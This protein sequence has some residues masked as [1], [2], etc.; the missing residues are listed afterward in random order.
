MASTLPPTYDRSSTHP[1]SPAVDHDETA[2][3]NF[4]TNL[5]VHLNQQVFPGNR[6]AFEK[7]VAPA[8]QKTQGK[9]LE[10]RQQV[11]DA[12]RKDPHY[13]SWAALRRNTMEQ[14]QQAGRHVVLRQLDNLVNNAKAHNTGKDTLLLNKDTTVPR[15]LA[16]V[17]NHC[18]PGSYH[19]GVVDDDVLAGVNYEA[20]I[21]VTTAGSMSS[22]GD[23]GGRAVV[24]FVKQNAP[25]FKPRR[26]L[27]LGAGIGVNTLPI[28]AAYP[29][30]EVIAVDVG[31]PMLRWGHARAQALEYKNVRFIQADGDALDIEPNSI[32][33]VQ[34]TMFWHET[35]TSAFQS[36]MKKIY[37]MMTP[38]GLCLNVEQPNFTPDTSLYDQFTRDWDAWYNNE[39]FWSK[40]HVMDV[41]DVMAKAGFS[42]EHMFEGGT[43][44]DIEQGQFQ[45]W[46][47]TMS[48]HSAELHKG[49]RA[50]GNGDPADVSKDCGDGKDSKYKGERWYLFGG[51]K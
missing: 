11:R 31:A 13:Q 16:A 39:P 4:L 33:W 17:D 36:M 46:S 30:A 20:G 15:Y 2:R 3:F 47:S 42:K 23:G 44:A 29:E 40:L 28:A 12:M 6:L 9:A 8:F 18:M 48:R 5:N 19:T 43:E 49:P 25:D 7:R 32:D 1:L 21:F 34:T 51:W 14:R 35:S 41:F 50:N 37:A 45:P 10:T 22:R 26:I 24:N 38:G 27:D